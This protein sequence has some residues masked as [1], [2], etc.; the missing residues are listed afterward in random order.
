MND[1]ATIII[2]AAAMLAGL[3]LGLLAGAIA[4]RIAARRHAIA[5]ARTA[6]L[7]QSIILP[8]RVREL[9]HL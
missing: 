7:T 2:I 1:I 6:W 4:R 9:N 3:I 8:R 5:R